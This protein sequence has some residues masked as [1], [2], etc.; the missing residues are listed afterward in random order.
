[1]VCGWRKDSYSEM[2]F[3]VAKG[4]VTEDFNE[5]FNP[6][7]VHRNLAGKTGLFFPFLQFRNFVGMSEE[8]SREVI[9]PLIDHVIQEK[10]M[11]HHNWQDGDVVISEQWL[12]IHKRW[13]FENMATR[14]LHR[15]MFDFANCDL[16]SL[17][18]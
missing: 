2:D 16:T 17:T 13:R 12:G 6:G 9:K 4:G 3:G 15:G 8:Q 14:V 18:Q 5:H 11:Y 7:L 10:Y 1:M